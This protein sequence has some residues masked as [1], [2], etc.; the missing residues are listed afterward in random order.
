[1]TEG[2]S[3]DPPPLPRLPPDLV[4]SGLLAAPCSSPMSCPPASPMD[5]FPEVLAPGSSV[6]EK[7]PTSLSLP[8]SGSSTPPVGSFIFGSLK[9]AVLSDS[10][11]AS[12]SNKTAPNLASRG[13][14]S[15]PPPPAA[16]QPSINPNPTQSDYNWA[17][18]LNSA[19]KF[20]PSSATVSTSAEGKPRVKIPNG[21][22]ERGA[23]IH[24][25]FIVG[26]FYGKAPS[27]GKI[28]AVLNYLWGKDKRVTIHHLAN[29]AYIFYIPSPSLR[30]RILQH[31][32]WRV[33]DSPFFVTEWKAE[34]SINPPSL[35]KA[36]V[37]A[38]IQGIPFDL[39]TYE[40]LSSI[41]SPLG[42]VV[43]A[44]PFTSISSAEVKVIADLTKPLPAEIELECDDG[45][46]L[47]LQLTY[48]WLPPLC[49][50]CSEIGHKAAFCPSSKAK[51]KSDSKG[52]SVVNDTDPEHDWQAPHRKS[53]RKKSKKK[54]SSS[55]VNATPTGP[56]TSKSVYVEKAKPSSDSVQVVSSNSFLPLQ[57][58]EAD[59]I[60]PVPNG[61]LEITNVDKSFSDEFSV[62]P[63]K[64]SDSSIQ[65]SNSL[66]PSSAMVLISDK[67]FSSAVSF[68]SSPR[69]SA[70]RKKKKRK[71]SSPVR[72]GT[73]GPGWSLLDNY[74]Q[75]PLGKIWF[76][77]RNPVTVRL[78][79]ADLQSIT[80]EVKLESGITI[81]Y[82]AIYASNDEDD[83][84]DL[85]I[86]LRDTCAAFDLS[87]K[88]WMVGGDFNEILHP[89]ETSN[90]GIITTTR[91]MRMFGECLGDL[92]LFDLPFTGPKYTWTNKRPAEPIGKKLDRCLVN[93]AW[94]LQFPS[95]YCEFSAPEF[96]DHSPCHIHLLSPP[97]SFGSRP[98]RFFNLL[99]KNSQFLDVVKGS[100]L[101]A[102]SRA[103]TLR[104][105]C[106]KLKSMK[107]PMKTLHRDNYSDIEKRVQAAE[108]SLN[109]A[110]LIALD[111]PTPI[112]VQVEVW[113][114][115]LWISLRLAEESFFRQRSRVK[116]L[117]EGDFN[118]PFYH[119]MMTIR[120]ALNAVK[121][122]IRDDGTTTNSLQEVHALAVEYF[123]GILCTIRGRFW[124]ALPEF[125][126]VIIERKCPLPVQD[127]CLL[128]YAPELIVSCLQKMKSNK[129]PGPDGFPA[130]FFRAAWNV[131]GQIVNFN[132]CHSLPQSHRPTD[133]MFLIGL[134][135]VIS[136]DL[137]SL[138][139]FGRQFVRVFR[140]NLGLRCAPP[141]SWTAC[142]TWL[143]SAS[144]DRFI[145]IALLQAWQATVY[146][147]W[148][149]RN[150]R[151]HSGL[152]V[153]PSVLK[154]KIL[155]TLIEKCLALVSLGHSLGVPLLRIWKPP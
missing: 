138:G 123:E 94:I 36:P 75:S 91:A 143:P 117:G 116:W 98:F 42:R 120:N 66:A 109:S 155:R 137:S 84:K 71:F 21:V 44:K 121:Q 17:S 53:K 122:L 28:W 82:T 89:D 40:G 19:S 78:L 126:D 56:S 14:G 88:P 146:S 64:V 15:S 151:F 130:E 114:K 107:R 47:I 141:T 87:N 67:G 86:S 6:L 135:M 18:H 37:W 99:T 145:K 59:P 24:N 119:G 8:T 50:V 110:Q 2:P 105:F 30:K 115:D 111:D 13:T 131:P 112:N 5:L 52:K 83:R 148:Q 27:Y 9:P 57:S 132:Y 93:G 11:P 108:A 92:G 127:E 61:E 55:E 20:P 10:A 70:E 140:K 49:P 104:D 100:W 4:H 95:S 139:W 23:K 26:I 125:L 45:K 60:A 65:M 54:Q 80:C 33:G 3:P 43:D 152:T 32:L 7:D 90:P 29:N 79:Y 35:D 144:S 118:T 63:S 142:L 34:F 73:S 68:S 96:S 31:E 48:P 39:I 25:D 113:A 150:L 69:S 51:E 72:Q 58:S 76:I 102:G 16:A 46:I 136:R 1:M 62:G 22:F 101:M 85:W 103:F 38:K 106:F 129:T 134:S 41:C 74:H 124:P 77:F 12:V 149:E 154:R 128:P 153:P 81:V 133:Q 97:P 147:L